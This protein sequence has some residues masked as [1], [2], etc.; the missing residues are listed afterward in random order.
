MND[1]EEH[2]TEAIL[3]ASG[4][5]GRTQSTEELPT[6]H[7]MENTRKSSRSIS[8]RNEDSLARD[9]V[10]FD[11]LVDLLTT[12]GLNSRDQYQGEDTAE[13]V[14]PSIFQASSSGLPLL[15]RRSDPFQTPEHRLDVS[16]KPL[17][18]PH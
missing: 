17:M 16:D 5:S 14:H 6:C 12:D 13:V 9:S 8:M 11:E 1:G 2:L 18:N 15:T 7:E 10:R 4:I 3:P